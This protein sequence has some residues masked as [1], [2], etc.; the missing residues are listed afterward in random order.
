MRWIH[1]LNSVTWIYL[2]FKISYAQSKYLDLII[3]IIIFCSLSITWVSKFLGFKK[4]GFLR[5]SSRI[6]TGVN[7]SGYLGCIILLGLGIA[8]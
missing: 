3:I 1:D 5:L 8:G 2:F 7:L 4:V 6:M